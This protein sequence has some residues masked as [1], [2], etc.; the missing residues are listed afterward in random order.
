MSAIW[1]VPLTLLGNS[2]LP[3][4]ISTQYRIHTSNNVSNELRNIR[5]GTEEVLL[6][7]RHF[8]DYL[9]TIGNETVKI[10][11]DSRCLLL[12]QQLADA[13]LRH[14]QHGL[15]CESS[16]MMIRNCLIRRFRPN[17]VRFVGYHSNWITIPK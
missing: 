7:N 17:R 6:W 3:D 15:E 16:R 8:V 5:I 2:S 10:T 14:Q 11:S 13:Y 4:E 12:T 1:L 9:M